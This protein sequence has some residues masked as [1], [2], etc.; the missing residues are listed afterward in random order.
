M[1]KQVLQ[2]AHGCAAQLAEAGE[3]AEMALQLFLTAAHSA[4]EYARLE[5]IA[6][7]FFEQVGTKTPYT[8][9]LGLLLPYFSIAGLSMGE[10]G[11]SV[12]LGR[13]LSISALAGT[14][15]GEAVCK[16]ILSGLPAC[17]RFQ[18]NGNQHS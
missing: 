18:H 11:Q 2:F 5:L 1:C 12:E 9:I 16:I 3:S 17:W 10:A 15:T 7:E 13:T 6:Y 14:L 8:H 4:S